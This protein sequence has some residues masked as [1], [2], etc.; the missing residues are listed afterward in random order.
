VPERQKHRLAS[1]VF[2]RLRFTLLR[3]VYSPAAAAGAICHQAGAYF[4]T[5]TVLECAGEANLT[6]GAVAG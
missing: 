1:G 4:V 2:V 3:F 6:V 5:G